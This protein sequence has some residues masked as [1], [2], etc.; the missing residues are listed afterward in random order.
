M[1]FFSDKYNNFR[2]PVISIYLN[3]KEINSK[4][5]NISD[6][7]VDLIRNGSGS[8]RFVVS[9]A[10]GKD[11]KPKFD[12]ELNF[13]NHVEIALGYGDKKETVIKGFISS[14]RYIFKEEN[15]LDIEVEGYDYLFML[16][17]NRPI[18]SWNGQKISEIVEFLTQNYPIKNKKIQ[19]TKI[20]FDYV[21]QSGKS[22]LQFLRYLSEKA[23]YEFLIIDDTF[24][25][26]EP[27]IG[28]SADFSL[29]FGV[30][31]MELELSLD[32]SSVFNR[33]S[34]LG[35]DINKKKRFE[36]QLDP[37]DEPLLNSDGVLGTQVVNKDL[38]TEL[39]VQL[40][41]TSANY[42]EAETEGKSL[43]YNRSLEFADLTCTAV[44][45]PDI[46]PSSVLYVE[47]IG[48]RFSKNYFVERVIHK[49]SGNGF[50]TLLKLRGNIV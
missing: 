34:V 35:W 6:I 15:F 31:I 1:S 17:K 45:I 24:Y 47:K 40:V 32:I 11:F 48:D 50:K 29:E 41:S 23:S 13:G 10:I 42:E 20:K 18:R 12:Q 26:R 25:F 49:F 21:R 22:D 8:F 16:S 2:S 38:K 43:F 14:L 19:D 39:N 44:G 33:V 30:D 28:R 3:D 37:G 9:E 46:K 7:E 36:S 4:E 27:P 5:I